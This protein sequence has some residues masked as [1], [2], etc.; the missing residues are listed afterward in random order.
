[1]QLILKRL[2]SKKDERRPFPREKYFM[3]CIINE[4]KFVST[5]ALLFSRSLDDEY[6]NLTICRRNCS[7]STFSH[8]EQVRSA[9]CNIFPR[10]EILLQTGEDCRELKSLR[11]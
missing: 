7:Q 5:L 8:R 6:K 9:P 11:T 4:I 2:T 10:W 1:M 3:K